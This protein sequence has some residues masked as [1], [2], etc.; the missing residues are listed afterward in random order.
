MNHGHIENLEIVD[1]YYPD[2]IAYKTRITAPD[3]TSTFLPDRKIGF[4]A[5]NK[6]GFTDIDGQNLK[7]LYEKM[8]NKDYDMKKVQQ[9]MEP[10]L[11]NKL[12][13]KNIKGVIFIRSDLIEKTIPGF[14]KKIRE[15]QFV[16]ASIDILRGEIKG[17]KK[18]KYIAEVKQF[19]ADNK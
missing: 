6:F 5:G 13:H 10:D 2:F 14:Q 15:R 4:I 18:E 16:N 12:L 8:F 1:A 19:F 9:T 7:Q 17:N 3:R 11:Y